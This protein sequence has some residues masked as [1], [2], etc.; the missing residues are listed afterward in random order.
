MAC[1]TSEAN[2]RGIRMPVPRA[3]LHAGGGLSSL[4]PIHSTSCDHGSFS[5]VLSNKGF[6][7]P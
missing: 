6:Q 3:C 5:N 4:R 2:P 1:M 7:L